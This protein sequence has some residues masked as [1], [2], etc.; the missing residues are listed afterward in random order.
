MP[1][2]KAPSIGRE[3]IVIESVDLKR[4]VALVARG[5]SISS[6][7]GIAYSKLEV[8]KCS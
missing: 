8:L 1:M 4:R 3:L 6:K 7:N 2:F 5:I